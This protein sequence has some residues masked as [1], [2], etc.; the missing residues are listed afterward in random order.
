M[1]PG[2]DFND[3]FSPVAKVTSIRLMIALATKFDYEMEQI[4][5]LTAYLSA[6]MDT[7]VYV[8]L[9]PAFNTNPGLQPEA[10][11]SSTVHRLLKGIPGIPQGGRLFNSKAH[12]VLK[13]LNFDRVPDDH[14][15]Y[16]HAD[17]DLF[18]LIY[19]DDVV[20]CYHRRDKAL[21]D[22]ILDKLG[23]QLQ[24]RVLGPVS[25]LLGVTITRDRAARKTTLDQTAMVR[26]LLA[27]TGMTDCKAMSTPLPSKARFTKQDCSSTPTTNATSDSDVSWYRTAVCSCIYLQLWTRVDI[28]YA[29]SKL[30]K[31][32]QKPGPVHV[33]YAKH[34]LMYLKGNPSR[35]L[36]YD[37]SKTAPRKGVY[38]Y[39]DAAHLDD[40][41]TR[42]STMAFIMFFEGC[43]ISWKS[44]LHTFLTLSTNNSEY[45]AS[46]KCAREAKWLWNI[47]NS[48]GLSKYVKPIVLF[49]DSQGAISLA[50]NPVLHESNKHVEV[51]DHYARELVQR[52]IIDITFVGTKEMLADAL[53]K[54]LPARQFL[55]LICQY[56]AE[57][58]TQLKE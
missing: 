26:T 43:A 15:F 19:V 3:T 20:Y 13:D 41:D 6:K 14:C 34:L 52:G 42:R 36:S 22:D 40:I 21:A 18:I 11:V 32:L 44:K 35:C 48:I 27:R 47:Y 24:L 55:Y 46:A 10:Q 28:A 57:A 9:P 50:Y 30:S 25:D 16:K 54:S 38:G 1:M 33:A 31:F 49:S 58:P 56:M 7:E 39:Y 53:T 12:T 2:V 37:F 8:R 51:A 4:D 23:Q 45:V 5:V 17:K 29:V